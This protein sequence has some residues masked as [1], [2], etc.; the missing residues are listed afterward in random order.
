MSGEE[1]YVVGNVI[2]GKVIDT[3]NI[4]EI[5]PDK[6]LEN[7]SGLDGGEQNVIRYMYGLG[8]HNAPLH[9]FEDA[10]I[11]FCYTESRLLEIRE[12]FVSGLRDITDILD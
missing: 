12:K 6:Y 9:S 3:V 10:R 1:H 5:L 11:V 7:I 4:K 8:G 2:D